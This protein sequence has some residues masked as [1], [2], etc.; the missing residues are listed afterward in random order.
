MH[1]ER[2]RTI[3]RN[4]RHLHTVRRVTP[5][6]IGHGVLDQEHGNQQAHQNDWKRR[7]ISATERDGQRDS[8]GYNGPVGGGVESG[9]SDLASI[10]LSPIE[11]SKGAD[12]GR[13]ETGVPVASVNGHGRS[14]P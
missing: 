5:D 14:L 7:G 1:E 10:H 3:R 9:P 2:R 13:P 6:L 8:G 12:F 4:P 11:M